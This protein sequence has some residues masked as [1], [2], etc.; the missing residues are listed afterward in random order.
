M[1]PLLL[2]HKPLRLLRRPAN[3]P[4]LFVGYC[5]KPSAFTCLKTCKTLQYDAIWTSR[6]RRC[7]GK[8]FWLWALR[9]KHAKHKSAWA[10]RLCDMLSP[11][12]FQPSPGRRPKRRWSGCDVSGC[13]RL[14]V[15]IENIVISIPLETGGQDKEP[16]VEIRARHGRVPKSVLQ[17]AKL[18]IQIAGVSMPAMG[19]AVGRAARVLWM[20]SRSAANR[21][22][23][24]DAM[25]HHFVSLVF[26]SGEHLRSRRCPH[27]ATSGGL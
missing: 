27:G 5:W 17:A 12:S 14:H 9:R 6:S 18:E 7:S 24:R 25:L 3:P 8:S 4:I 16:A 15:A 23:W 10:C 11:R 26:L 20:L 2:T 1:I 21:P 19:L 22:L 13:V